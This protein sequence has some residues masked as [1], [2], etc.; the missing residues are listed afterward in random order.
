MGLAAFEQLALLW[1]WT[2]FYEGKEAAGTRKDSDSW[3]DDK[4]LSGMERSLEKRKVW[5]IVLS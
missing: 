5:A 3:K 2:L 1:S 4:N